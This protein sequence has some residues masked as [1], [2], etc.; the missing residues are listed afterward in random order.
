MTK[1]EM[2]SSVLNDNKLLTKDTHISRRHVL[3]IANSKAKQLLSQRV[4]EFKLQNS[5][6]LITNIPCLELEQVEW[7]D[8]GII[9]FRLCET[10]MKSKCK[11]PETITGRSATAVFYVASL[12]GSV[13]FKLTTPRDFALLK[14]RKY[15]NN[16]SNFYM[17]K[18]GHIFLPDSTT[19][20]V[21]MDL[22]TMSEKEARDCGCNNEED[23][24]SLWDEKF[25]CTDLL[26][27]TVRQQTVQEIAGI[28]ARTQKDENP[29]LDENQ[30]S[31]TVK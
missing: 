6:D 31:A 15:K 13:E 26:L 23:C 12:D 20:I 24:T 9:E 22:I 4:D 2:V 28:Y 11:L 3:R 5:Y 8:C 21:T 19:E 1:G 17:I 25:T 7:V 14:R 18:D 16:K 10:I 27:E 30:R 29:N